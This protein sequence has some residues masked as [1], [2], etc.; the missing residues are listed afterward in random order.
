MARTRS[1]Y[2]YRERMATLMNSV[3]AH[4]ADR[5]FPVPWRFACAMPLDPVARSLITLALLCILYRLQQHAT[6]SPHWIHLN[7]CDGVPAP[8]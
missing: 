7:A 2:C 6:V 4:R 5:F 8:C 1:V 3:L